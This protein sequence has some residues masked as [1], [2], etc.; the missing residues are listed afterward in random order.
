MNYLQRV[1]RILLNRSYST[2]NFVGL[3]KAI[4]R[5]EGNNYYQIRKSN[6]QEDSKLPS[7]PYVVLGIE[8]SCDDTGIGIVRSDGT[9]IANV[10]LSQVFCCFQYLNVII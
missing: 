3:P 8:T 10:V 4:D 7:K 6:F 5:L 1:R 9:I 2:G